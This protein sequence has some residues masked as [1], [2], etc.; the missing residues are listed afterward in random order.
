LW[1]ETFS[2]CGVSR[3]SLDS[4]SW[5]RLYAALANG[6]TIE[7]SESRV[8][9]DKIRERR[10]SLPVL[11]LLGSALYTS[12]MAGHAQVSN[13]WLVCRESIDCGLVDSLRAGRDQSSADLV[14]EETRVRHVD[15]E[16]Q[17]PDASGVGPM[18][19]TVEVVTTG[20]SLAGRAVIRGEIEAAAWAHAIEQVS[21][22]G[23]KS[24]A[25]FGEV[26]ISH[27]GDAGAYVDWLQRSV[28]DGSLRER[29]LTLA[30]EL[31]PA[32]KAKKAKAKK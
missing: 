31:G 18:P 4:G 23:G 5:D 14:S 12:H 25:G 3:E 17:S 8:S 26:E 27:D 32:K 16:E 24:A 22:L 20:A 1:R 28:D 15:Q 7:A 6:G 13:S 2:A 30:S 9:P 21:H 29:L 10:A 11:S 19:T